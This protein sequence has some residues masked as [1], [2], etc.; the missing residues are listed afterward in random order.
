MFVHKFLEL[1]GTETSPE[2]YRAVQGFLEHYL[3]VQN[4]LELPAT[5][6]ILQ[7]YIEV[8]RIF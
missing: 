6:R 7:T 5:V 1:S 4:V 8:S 2:L 3:I